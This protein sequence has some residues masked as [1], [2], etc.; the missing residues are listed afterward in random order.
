[1]E[2]ALDQVPLRVE[3][4]FLSTVL[5]VLALFAIAVRA[6]AERTEGVAVGLWTVRAVAGA[7]IWLAATGLVALTGV[8]RDF[9]LPPRIFFL[10]AVSL[11]LTFSIAYSRVGTA[12]VAGIGP[13]GLIGFQLFRLPVEIFLHGMYQAGQTPVQMTYAGLNFDIFSGLTAPAMA[14]LVWRGKA[15]R[16]MIWGWNIFALLLLVN[17]VTIGIFSLPTEFR[18]FMNEPANTFVAYVPYV[19]LPAVL[20]Q[21]ALLGHLLIFRWLWVQRV[22]Y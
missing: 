11:A 8:L 16:A 18:I 10:L 21:A 19:W 1:M 6:A 17:I 12:L 9:S 13:V 2:L 20:V 14:W 3:V 5:G 4:L 15:G 7:A 22:E